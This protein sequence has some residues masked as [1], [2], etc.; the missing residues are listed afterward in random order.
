[1]HVVRGFNLLDLTQIWLESYISRLFLF[2]LRRFL[3]QVLFEG[4]FARVL[5]QVLGGAF[6]LAWLLLHAHVRVLVAPLPSA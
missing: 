3:H 4:L 2:Y 1:M 6:R 5:L